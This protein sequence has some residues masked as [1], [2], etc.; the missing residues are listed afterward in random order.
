MI[1]RKHDLPVKRQ[2]E[3]VG[4]SRGSVYYLP[5]PVSAADL[6]LMRVIDELHLEHPFAG[7]RMLRDMLKARGFEAGRKHVSTLMRRMG[8]E[9]LY[10]KPNT[11]KRHP[12]HLIYPYLLRGVA[13]E[14]ANHAWAMDISAPCRRGLQRQRERSTRRSANRSWLIHDRQLQS[15]LAPVEAGRKGA[16]KLGRLPTAG[17]HAQSSLNCTEQGRLRPVRRATARSIMARQRSV[18]WK[19]LYS[20]TPRPRDGYRGA[21]RLGLMFPSGGCARAHS[22]MEFLPQ[23]SSRATRGRA[24]HLRAYP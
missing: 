5:T 16:A 4:I 6:T 2:A 17:C 8:I 22:A 3:L 18:R 20:A 9:A 19:P 10:R 24:R 12:Q 21:I 23:P 11:S 14:R 15:C 1:D 13:I 7:A